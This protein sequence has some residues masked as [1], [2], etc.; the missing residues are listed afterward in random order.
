MLYFSVSY[1][2]LLIFNHD[3][4]RKCKA[5]DECIMKFFWKIKRQKGKQYKQFSEFSTP[6]LSLFVAVLTIGIIPLVIL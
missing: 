3:S 1:F 2:I 5:E 4:L 6:P